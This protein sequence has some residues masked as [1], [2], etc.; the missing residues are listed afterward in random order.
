[1]SNATYRVRPSGMLAPYLAESVGDFLVPLGSNTVPALGEL[2]YMAVH[3][4]AVVL[5]QRHEED[6][7]GNLWPDALQ[8]QQLLACLVI[9]H[10]P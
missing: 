4:N 3:R 2:E 9:R 7:V 1:M 10:V 5:V 6:T 8:L